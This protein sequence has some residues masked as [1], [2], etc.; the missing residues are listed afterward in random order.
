MIAEED[1]FRHIKF[2]L[3]DEE[4]TLTPYEVSEL[5]R[6]LRLA[7][8]PALF[9]RIDENDLRLFGTTSVYIRW[10]CHTRD[11]QLMLMKVFRR[12][13]D[14]RYVRPDGSSKTIAADGSDKSTQ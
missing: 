5:N 10:T 4:I 6:E 14:L 3:G 7:D 13:I 12:E 1:E 2:D 11:L 8:V 9:V